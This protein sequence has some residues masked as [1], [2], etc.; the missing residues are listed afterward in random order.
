MDESNGWSIELDNLKAQYKTS[1]SY[2]INPK[3]LCIINPGNPTGQV[4]DRVI[5]EQIIRFAYKKKLLIFADEV[6]Q[7]NIYSE[8]KK[9]ISFKKVVSEIE[10]PYN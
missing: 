9:F 4:L 2:G 8:T 3:L 10:A 7:K 5:I 6:Y 1:R